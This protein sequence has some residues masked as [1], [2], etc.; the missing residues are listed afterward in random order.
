MSTRP[1]LPCVLVAGLFALPAL[2]QTQSPGQNP[3]QPSS[4]SQSQNQP[5]GQTQ[6][7]GAMQ[8]SQGAMQPSQGAG[9]SPGS[10]GNLAFMTAPDQSLVGGTGLVGQE[11]QG[12]NN[13]AIGHVEDVLVDRNGR[14][15]GLVINVG[16]YI[17][18]PDSMVGVPMEAI[19]L[20]TG[21]QPSSTGAVGGPSQGGGPQGDG[22]QSGSQAM[23]QSMPGQSGS[24]PRGIVVVVTKP[25]LQAAPKYHDNAMASPSDT[26]Q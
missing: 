7:P 3:N 19:R 17:G 12:A 6:S 23:S 15:V 14:I 22:S 4:P 11:V 26:P 21:E 20:A 1:L 5:S 16:D 10:G 2:A 25:Q 9:R 18:S 13:E 8:P 24:A